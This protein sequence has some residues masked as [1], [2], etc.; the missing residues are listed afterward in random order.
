VGS[1]PAARAKISNNLFT[2]PGHDGRS[3]TAPRYR[4]VVRG[5]L[6]DLGVDQHKLSDAAKLQIRIAAS[7]AARLCE[8]ASSAK[9]GSDK[10]YCSDAV[11]CGPIAS[12]RESSNGRGS[13]SRRAD[14]PM[15]DRRFPPPG[16]WTKFQADS[17]RVTPTGN[18]SPMLVRE[19]TLPTPTGGMTNYTH[20]WMLRRRSGHPIGG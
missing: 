18:R 4:D 10:E 9:N 3:A 12:A 15:T 7:T 17:L 19:R 8:P 13:M 16:P 1:F 2:L 20:Q 14:E 6:R 11:A 5:I